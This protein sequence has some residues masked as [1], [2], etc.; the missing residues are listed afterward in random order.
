MS[1]V[2]TLL[3]DILLAL[4]TYP[5]EFPAELVGRVVM[6]VGP[7]LA[8]PMQE[9]RSYYP[10]YPPPPPS[11]YERITTDAGSWAQT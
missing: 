6:A 11:P 2:D 10:V 4:V 9:P 5:H 7:R 1:D 8:A 3:A